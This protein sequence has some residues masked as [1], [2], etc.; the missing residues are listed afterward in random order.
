MVGQYEV[1]WGPLSAGVILSTGPV[2][3]LF[4]FLRQHLIHGLTAGAV[5]G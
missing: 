4:S 3:V 1:Q 2:A 5:K